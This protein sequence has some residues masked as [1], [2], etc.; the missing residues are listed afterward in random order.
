MMVRKQGGQ[1]GGS[2]G[3]AVGRCYCVRRFRDCFSVLLRVSAR[4]R[5]VS[6]P[7]ASISS[8][9]AS[10]TGSSSSALAR[11]MIACVSAIVYRRKTARP[12]KMLAS[13]TLAPTPSSLAKRSSMRVLRRVPAMPP[14]KRRLRRRASRA[15]REKLT[16]T[17]AVP[18]RA[19]GGI[20]GSTAAAK[21]MTLVA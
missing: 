19:F 14:R 1:A 3:K 8:V 4:A 9:R 13:Y 2:T 7:A 10:H 6:T 16:K 12:T 18:S 11:S 20:D 5:R 15:E 21:A 17:E